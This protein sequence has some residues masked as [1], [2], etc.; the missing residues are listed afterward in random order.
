LAAWAGAWSLTLDGLTHAAPLTALAAAIALAC[1]A[2]RTFRRETLALAAAGLIFNGALMLSSPQ[3]LA[4][5]A[6]AGAGET[7]SIVQ[8]NAWQHNR[9]PERSAEWVL[10]QDADFVLVE[11]GSRLPE[12]SARLAERYPFQ[13]TCAPPSEC[14]VVIY[15]K[16]K[17][18][19]AQGYWQPGRPMP[20]A[21]GRFEHAGQPMDIVAVHMGWPLPAGRQA[22]QRRALHQV[23]APLPAGSLILGG[24]FNAAPWSF[25]LRRLAGRLHLRRAE[26]LAWTWPAEPFSRLRLRAPAPFL[27]IDHVFAG[28]DWSLVKA[29]RGPAIGSDHYPLLVVLNRKRAVA[30][31]APLTAP[32]PSRK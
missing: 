14:P 1:S 32:P 8:F 16:S 13:V 3:G 24:D 2:V 5:A 23:A 17:P 30:L 7:V 11:E 19:Q 9:S 10:R 12:F 20:F 28:A 4:R 21:R 25:G 31:A 27:P 6:S 22:E 29:Q 15:A 18:L 26:G